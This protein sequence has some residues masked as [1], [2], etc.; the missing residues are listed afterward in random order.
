MSRAL[1]EAYL[2]KRRSINW[3]EDPC[4]L[5][6]LEILRAYLSGAQGF[7]LDCGSGESEPVFICNE[8]NCVVVD[9]ATSGLC[10][11]RRHGFKG[12]L[13]L[14]SCIHLPF[15]EN[16]FER[17][18]CSEVIEHLPR[19][20]DVKAA[21]NELSRVSSSFVVTTPKNSRFSIWVEPTHIH[22]FTIRNIQS[23]L[24]GA[25]VTTNRLSD[26]VFP[27]LLVARYRWLRWVDSRL[28][29]IRGRR[30]PAFRKGFLLGLKGRLLGGGFIIAV[31]DSKCHYLQ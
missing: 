28:K 6:R 16:V 4:Q 3:L 19:L 22:F 10:N 31:R 29:G 30:V 8:K 15:A 25:Y 11:L 20:T 14:A 23:L 5:K 26:T 27:R 12:A 13:I 2:A 17:A 24:K 9:I 1:F 7:K 18:V 21:L